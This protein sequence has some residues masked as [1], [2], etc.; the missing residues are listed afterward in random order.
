MNMDDFAS[1]G[2]GKHGDNHMLLKWIHES[3][4]PV[5][6]QML[7]EEVPGVSADNLTIESNLIAYINPHLPYGHM[8][9]SIILKFSGKLVEEVAAMGIGNRLKRERVS[10]W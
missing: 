4:A 9:D 10:D 3:L 1:L 5:L 2:I 8:P 7:T 6:A